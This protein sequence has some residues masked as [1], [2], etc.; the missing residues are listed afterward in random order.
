[1]RLEQ[2]TQ[3]VIQ[4]QHRP[5]WFGLDAGQYVLEAGQI[6]NRQLLEKIIETPRGRRALRCLPVFKKSGEIGAYLRFR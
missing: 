5:G 4:C 2:V 3:L 6:D 1:M